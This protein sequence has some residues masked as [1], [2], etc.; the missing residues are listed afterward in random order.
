MTCVQKCASIWSAVRCCH[1]NCRA[2]TLAV[3]SCTTHPW[4]GENLSLPWAVHKTKMSFMASPACNPCPEDPERSEII[5][6]EVDILVNIRNWSRAEVMPVRDLAEQGGLWRRVDTVVGQDC[7]GHGLA[8]GDGGRE[9]A[10]VGGGW[11]ALQHLQQQ[12]HSGGSGS[13]QRG[14]AKVRVPKERKL[15]KSLNQGDPQNQD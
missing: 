13:T 8:P 10:R 7:A 12:N 2:L 5:Y 6:V 1:W 4:V 11:A 14:Y 15:G 9:K 3:F